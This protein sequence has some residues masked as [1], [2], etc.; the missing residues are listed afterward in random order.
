MHAR[1]VDFPYDPG[2]FGSFH[3]VTAGEGL[4]HRACGRWIGFEP[5]GYVEPAQAMSHE[6]AQ[7]LGLNAYARPNRIPGIALNKASWDG[8]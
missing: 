3:V 4:P 2:S 5:Y 6:K 7:R 1:I 8:S